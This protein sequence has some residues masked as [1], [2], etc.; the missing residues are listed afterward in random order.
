M[1]LVDK[2]SLYDRN[3]R[4]N[5][6]GNVGTNPPAA[7]KYFAEDGQNMNSPFRTKGGPVDDLHKTLLEEDVF[8][9]NTGT[10]YKKSPNKSPFQDLH[11]GATDNFSGQLPNP[12]LG[13]FGGPYKN[14][15]PTDG[16][17]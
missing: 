10:V 13:Q 17:Y 5:L 12:T 8:S 16:Y 7:G 15:G 3:S 1:S 4:E 11:P 2:K 14:I 6:G 9:N